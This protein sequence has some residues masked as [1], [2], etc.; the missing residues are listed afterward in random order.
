MIRRFTAVFTALA[1][2]AVILSGTGAAGLG[3]YTKTVR[4]GSTGSAV[5][6]LQE[7]LSVLG[8]YP[9]R[10]DGRAGEMTAGAIR[11]FQ[12]DHGLKTDGIAGP[13][14]W[15]VLV[16]EI[17]AL[18][19]ASAAEEGP[20]ETR[21]ESGA[22]AASEQAAETSA[23]ETVAP[24]A[25]PA[26]TGK[27]VI[28]PEA[29]AREPAPAFTPLKTTV[30]YGMRGE[31]VKALQEALILLGYRPGAA[32]GVCGG[33]T[34]AAIRA[35]QTDNGLTADGVAGKKT[36]DAVNRSMESRQAPQE[37][38]DTATDTAAPGE[39]TATPQGT[40]QGPAEETG[41][42]DAAAYVPAN[43]PLS[44]GDRGDGVYSLQR[45]LNILGYYSLTLDG[46]FG[47][48]TV[49]AV[50]AFQKTHGLVSDGVAG[51]K[52][53][54]AINK[55]LEK[56][57]SDPTAE[58]LREWM[59][60]LASTW[61]VTNGAAIITRD[62]E[63][64]LSWGWG[65]AHEDT[66]F[67]IASVTKWVTAIGLMTLYD[68]GLLDLDADICDYLPFTV[69][70]PGYPDQKITARMLLNHTA[71]LRPDA[72][73]Y[74]PDWERIGKGGY[75][76]VFMENLLPGTT[77]TYADFDGALMGSLIEAI[78]GESVQTYLDRTVFSPLGLTAAY[79]PRLLPEGTA[80]TDLLSTSGAVQISV[81]KDIDR[82]FS[83]TA[84]PAGNC[85]YTVGR[86]FINASSLSVLAQMMLEG[87]I[88]HGVKIL[89]ESTVR[90]MESDMTDAGSPYGLGQARLNQFPGGA[91]Y[92]HQGRYGGLTSNVYYQKETGITLV[93][94]LNG[95]DY[96]TENNVVL[97]AVTVLNNMDTLMSL[98]GATVD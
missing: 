24:E 90:L 68:R 11:A 82:E 77:Y 95:Y 13:R 15:E 69:R 33:G 50:K 53:I 71:S 73:N 47:Q 97:P 8:Y 64:V 84:D 72:T 46:S 18:D 36:L 16:A 10:V 25:G 76:P 66:C 55:A 91:W 98:A 1:L 88:W 94:I 48:G 57:L 81:Q 26:G 60:S 38:A 65:T 70:N 34:V 23:E 58:A 27:T 61:G 42:A 83:L 21:P 9:G 37:S 92:G 80:T 12:A 89:E 49:A 67:R 22:E 63:P 56:A 28:P 79:T 6:E 7:A 39:T 96:Q 59:D 3:A 78:T 86:L 51:M 20:S 4:Y 30:R 19:A 74:H 93:L 5:T 62:G 35:F 17:A 52:T 32:D 2:F 29:G 40:E 41:R 45:A 85:G 14:T 87:G 43:E 44:S 75:D 31:S 54:A